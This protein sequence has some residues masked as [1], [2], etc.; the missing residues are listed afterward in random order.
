M[1]ES[2]GFNLLATTNGGRLQAEVLLR[3]ARRAMERDPTGPPILI[4]HQDWS[5]ALLDV[6]ATPAD[7]APRYA[8]LAFEH[9]QDVAVDYRP[10][11][12][13][14]V[15]EGPAPRL[16][17]DVTI[18]WPDAPGV[19]RQY[20]YDDTLSTPHL[21]VTNQ[22]VIRYALLDFGDCIVF[23]EI[24]GLTGRPTSGALGLLFQ[25]IGEGRV[26]QYRMAVAPSGVVVSRGTARKAF[27]E[28]AA[29]V[30]VQP[31]GRS[32]KDVP[33]DPELR[34]LE[35][36]LNRPLKIRYRPR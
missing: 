23:D 36:R 27:F 19:A 15:V 12:A 13:S 18:S 5:A 6:T 34:A 30:T 7:R 11:W 17:L 4:R 8:V 24:E 22:R 31:D 25:L 20:S 35:Q 3:L 29:T 28:I 2:R 26:V 21:K 33:P 16:A 1:A 32:E 14:E 9:R 10:G